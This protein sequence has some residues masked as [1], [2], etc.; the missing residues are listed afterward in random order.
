MSNPPKKRHPLAYVYLTIAF[1]YFAASALLNF[2]IIADHPEILSLGW[3]VR[4]FL[5][6]VIGI[7][8]KCAY[9]MIRLMMG[10]ESDFPFYYMGILGM[11]LVAIAVALIKFG[12]PGDMLFLA[13]VMYLLVPAGL[14][15][16]TH[17]AVNM[18]APEKIE[19]PEEV[20]RKYAE[21]QKANKEAD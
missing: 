8:A 18:P 20:M 5:F 10:K 16:L 4:I 13:I 3:L 15:G 1:L 11:H 12:I 19:S 17:L 14:W 9:E 7:Y 21:R 6:V 2:W